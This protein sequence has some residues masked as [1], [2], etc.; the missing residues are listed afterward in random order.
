MTRDAAIELLNRVIVVPAT[1]SV[2]GIPTEVELDRNDGMPEDCVLS[3]D[4]VTVVS[5]HLIGRRITG[6]GPARMAQVCR[7]W[8]LVVDC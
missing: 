4:N 6:L 5:K 2:R 7:A 1:R 8:R 3:F